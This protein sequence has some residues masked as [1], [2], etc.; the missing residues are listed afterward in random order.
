MCEL[1]RTG[2]NLCYLNL[3]QSAHLE[4]RA[5]ATVDPNSVPVVT[6]GTAV[7]AVGVTSLADESYPATGIDRAHAASHIVG[8]AIDDLDARSSRLPA[9]A[10]SAATSANL[11]I[12]PASAIDPD[13]AGVVS[14]R[15]AEVARRAADLPNDAH[16]PARVGG[17]HLA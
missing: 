3:A 2:C 7:D 10:A 12:C 13:A 17:A 5:A 16:A 9:T 11:E 4:I 6:P 14:P 8:R 15:T 1:R